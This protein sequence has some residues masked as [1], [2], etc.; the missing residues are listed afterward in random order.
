MKKV[1]NMRNSQYTREFRDSTIQLVLNSGDSI[2]KIA[3][4]LD[5][6]SKTIYNWIREYKKTN[7]DSNE[8]VVKSPKETLE[9]ENKRLR[10]ETKLLRQERDVLKKAA[11]YFAKEVQ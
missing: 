10:R 1:E 4:D 2:L 11:V 3:K 7:Q 9:Q 5:V 8:V 6:N